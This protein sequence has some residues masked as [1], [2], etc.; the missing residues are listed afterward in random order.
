MNEDVL[1]KIELIEH[2]ID[3]IEDQYYSAG[4]HDQSTIEYL[5]NQINEISQCVDELIQVLTEAV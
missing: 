2:D 3:A 5:N 4:L 1:N